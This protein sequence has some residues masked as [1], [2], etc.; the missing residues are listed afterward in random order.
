MRWIL[1]ATTL[2]MAACC[3]PGPAMSATPD[4]SASSL[5][6]CPSGAEQVDGAKCSY[7]HDT[8]CHSPFGYVCTCVCT[9]YWECDQVKVVCD[10]DG[11][12]PHD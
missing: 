11:G 5:A 7:G 10:P 3:D 12:T 6:A 2:A 1:V 9:G 4:L 8:G